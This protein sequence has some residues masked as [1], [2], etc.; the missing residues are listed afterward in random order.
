MKVL[1]N[2]LK[3]SNKILLVVYL[4]TVI[5]YIVS[6]VILVKNLLGLSGIETVIR[7]VVI[8]LFFIWLI[9]YFLWN[10]INLILKKHI[11]ILITTIITVMF[12]IVFSFVNYYI[13]I[14]YTGIDNMGESEY[15]TYIS[16]LIVLKGKEITNDSKLG[17][18]NSKEDIEGNVLAKELIKDKKLNK[19]EIV[20]FSSYYEMIFALLNEEVEGIFL[21][22]N[23]LTMFSEDEF[24]GIANTEVFY[25]YSKKMKNQ[26]TTIV[27]NKKLTEPFTILLMGVDSETD[28]LDASTSFNGD[29]LMLITF[30]PKT[31]SA[32]MFSIP[33][34]TYVP[35]AC[36]NNRYAKINSSAAYGTTCVIDTIKQ[37]TDIDIDYYLKINFKG[38]VDLVEALGG[39]E[40]DVEGPDYRPYAIE[41]NGRICE[42][43]SLRQFGDQTICIDPGR[44]VLNGEQ[45]L[46]YA[47][48]RHAFVLSDIAR[49]K[50]QQQII[51]AMATKLASP[52]N[53]NRIEELLNAV[54]NNLST[55][56]SKN[57][58]LSFYEVMKSMIAKSFKDGDF[59]SI[60]KTYLEFYNLSVRP[61]SNSLALS[62]IGYYEGSLEAIVDLMKVNLGLKEKELIKTFS[63]DANTE[64]TTKPVGQGITTGEKLETV[65]NFSGS[66]VSVAEDWALN[67]NITLNTEFVDSSSPYYNP[68]AIPGVIVGQ[69]VAD[70]ILLKDVT[71]I[72]IYINDNSSSD[73]PKPPIDNDNNNGDDDDNHDNDEPTDDP[74]IPGIFPSPRGDQDNSDNNDKDKEN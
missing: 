55:N 69:S 21:S 23:Y 61:S 45:A 19:N 43:N 35:I 12:I 52:S 74:V 60:Q 72:T 36:N 50:H 54:T 32:T 66:A 6:F 65:P 39:I 14:I 63:F 5:T 59:I 4:I 10:L 73:L 9:V 57:Q 34:D 31:L 25:S 27:S 26:D 18:I 28:G 67:H 47:R 15:V 8:G 37:L 49:N 1:F 62:A 70:K 64:Y 56:M 42:Q 38:V 16:N 3:K 33:R 51:E 71:E 68:D 13:E 17:M 29:T 24:Q 44:Q 30:N 11:K 48:C 22:S 20:D 40:V 7:Y 46:A 53:I 58:M 2:K 41:N